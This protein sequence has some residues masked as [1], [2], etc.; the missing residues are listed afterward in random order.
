[1]SGCGTILCQGKGVVVVVGWWDEEITQGWGILALVSEYRM[2]MLI[3]TWLSKA[4][5][6]GCRGSMWVD[7]HVHVEVVA[8]RVGEIEW[9]V[10]CFTPN[11]RY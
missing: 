4:D 1:V 9:G 3:V 7:V 2:H 6:R 5:G 8:C 10:G 11:G